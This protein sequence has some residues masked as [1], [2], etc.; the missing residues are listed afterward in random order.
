MDK[1]AKAFIKS[2]LIYLGVGTILG[3]LMVFWPDAR[4]TMTRIHVHILLLGFMAMMI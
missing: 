1:Y 3:L 2:S 4:F